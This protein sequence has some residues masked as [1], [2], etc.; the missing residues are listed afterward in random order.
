MSKNIN[1]CNLIGFYH[2]K[3]NKGTIL[4]G[5]NKFYSIN[6]LEGALDVVSSIRLMTSSKEGKLISGHTFFL[7]CN[8]NMR[9]L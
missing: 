3:Y 1:V 5:E 8:E 2:K 6:T 4:V 7:V 9:Q